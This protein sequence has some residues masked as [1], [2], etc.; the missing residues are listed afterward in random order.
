MLLGL[1][2]GIASGKTTVSQYLK[3]LGMEVLDAD[4]I[5]RVVMEPGQKAWQEICEAFPQVILP[6]RT[7]DR[8]MLGQIIFRDAEQ[9]KRLEGILHPVIKGRMRLDATL[10]MSQGKKVV[11][12]I[13]LLFETHCEAFLERIWVVYVDYPLQL[14]RLMK[15]DTLTIEEA[16]QRIA[17]Q[18]P[19]EEKR[20][21]AQEVID[22]R[23][24]IEET[25]AQVLKLYQAL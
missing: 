18:M 5:G 7:I 2:G 21:L 24:T 17:S 22:N 19:L 25:K 12:D 8:K 3:T 9:K 10:L 11:L 13:P 1:T 23:G 20:L 4:A 15:R 14:E 16:G 6:D